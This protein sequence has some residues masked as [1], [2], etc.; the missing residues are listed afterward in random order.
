M[1]QKD[2]D[3]RNALSDGLEVPSTVDSPWS[4]PRTD[5]GTGDG[6][7]G[8]LCVSKMHKATVVR[9]G[10]LA[11][12]TTFGI[13]TIAV[14][15][16]MAIKLAA[17]SGEKAKIQVTVTNLHFTCRPTE[18]QLQISQ[19]GADAAVVAGNRDVSS[20]RGIND[21]LH[22]TDD[23]RLKNL[24]GALGINTDNWTDQGV[25]DAAKAKIDAVL[26]PYGKDALTGFQDNL[27]TTFA[28]EL[29]KTCRTATRQMCRSSSIS[30]R[31]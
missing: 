23:N 27:R 26:A 7:V 19:D 9:E 16:S 22:N 29:T 8:K 3:L 18:V 13:K 4:F 31:A 10:D 1:L 20:H 17:K 14:P 30:N 11:V 12:H 5:E 2:A 24:A 21:W 6:T 15:S 28:T 25:R